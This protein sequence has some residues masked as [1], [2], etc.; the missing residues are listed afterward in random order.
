VKE[1]SQVSGSYPS[2]STVLERL[3]AWMEAN[4]WTYLAGYLLW[5]ASWLGAMWAITAA[6][7]GEWTSVDRLVLGLL[8]LAMGML[9]ILL[10]RP[11][12]REDEDTPWWERVLTQI[13]DACPRHGPGYYRFVGSVIAG[14]GMGTLA[15]AAYPSTA[16]AVTAGI[17]GGLA[18]W[19][20]TWFGFREIEEDWE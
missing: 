2:R 17:I 10:S 18:I 7:M 15:S 11:F 6:E 14:A 13:M 16:F 8:L 9:T 19:V 4:H 5:I 20:A 1:W 12:A 3:L